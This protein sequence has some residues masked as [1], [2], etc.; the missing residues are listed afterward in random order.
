VAGIAH[1]DDVEPRRRDFGHIASAWRDIGAAAGTVAVGL[2]HVE[3]DAG[4]WSTPAHVH[5]AEEEIFYVLGGSGLS[6]QDDGRGPAAYELRPGDC[7]V[8]LADRETHTLR[9][10]ANGLVVLAFGMRATAE[11]CFLPRAGSAWV[12]PTWVDAGGGQHPYARE[13]K[14]GEPDVGEPMLDR[15]PTI[16]NVDD[17]D[18]QAFAGETVERVRRDLGRAAGSDRTG[19]QH[20]VVAPGKLGAPPHCHSAEEEIFVVLDGDGTF[21]LGRDEHPV[22]RGQVVARPPGSGVAH[23]LSA[24]ADGLTYLAYGTRDPSDLCYYPRSQKISFRGV[25]VVGRIEALDY[26]DGER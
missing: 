19:L 11:A 25:G 21:V 10:G 17:V 3:V 24:G 23:A 5:G 26:W 18:A 13:A 2:G 15:P 7:V 8:H 22:R 4:R 16:V 1:W 14:A 20:V 12:G 6:W 9:A